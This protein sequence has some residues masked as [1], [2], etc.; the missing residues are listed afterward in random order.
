MGWIRFYAAACRNK[1]VRLASPMALVLFRGHGRFCPVCETTSRKFLAFGNCKRQDACCPR[2]GALERHRL[3]WL[4]F[5]RHTNLFSGA[6]GK[7]LHVAPEPCFSSR[8]KKRLGENYLSG[9]LNSRRAM[10]KMDVTAIP[11]PD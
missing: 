2:G 8:L 6:A 7:M 9:D 3:A 11:F 4:F 5:A 10:V 1:I